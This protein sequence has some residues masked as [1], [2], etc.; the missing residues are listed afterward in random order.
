MKKQKNTVALAASI[1]AVGGAAV[2]L[3][4]EQLVKMF[5]NKK[6]NKNK[7]VEETSNEESSEE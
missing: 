6:K 3:G 5:I 7:A 4:S 1:S 2:A